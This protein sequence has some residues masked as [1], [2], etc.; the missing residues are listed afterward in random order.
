MILR[1]PISTL[2]PYTTLFQTSEVAKDITAF[3][4]NSADIV[5]KSVTYETSTT[6][7]RAPT[8]FTGFTKTS[9]SYN[10]SEGQLLYRQ[11]YR[12]G[13]AFETSLAALDSDGDLT[14]LTAY[15]DTT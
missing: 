4:T 9:A 3:T 6:Y 5:T 12:A 13:L 11:N 15:A 1:A 2:F 10:N 7:S 8:S 14:S